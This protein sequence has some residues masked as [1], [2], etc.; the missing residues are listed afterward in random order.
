MNDL[1]V[2]GDKYLMSFCTEV[3][4]KRFSALK[5]FLLICTS[6]GAA[7]AGRK[8]IFNKDWSKQEAQN[9]V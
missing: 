9:G 3:L 6:G 4:Q 7:K 5:G 8:Y 2:A 1:H